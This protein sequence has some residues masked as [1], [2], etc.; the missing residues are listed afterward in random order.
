MEIASSMPRNREFQERGQSFLGF[1]LV[2]FSGALLALR[3][4]F[5]VAGLLRLVRLVGFFG[6]LLAAFGF[7]LRA[8]SALPLRARVVGDVPPAALELDRGRRECLLQTAAA[9]RAHLERRFA[10]P[11]DDLGFLTAFPADVLV[12]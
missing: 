11:L 8:P 2:G 9:V 4:F 1:F 7:R 12:D 10:D 5:G 3:D 6:G